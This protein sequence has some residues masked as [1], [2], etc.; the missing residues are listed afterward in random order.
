[1][2]CDQ[3]L[4]LKN[5][6]TGADVNDLKCVREIIGHEFTQR[7]RESAVTRLVPR[8]GHIRTREIASSPTCLNAV[9]PDRDF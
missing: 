4:R 6:L 9:D 5:R 7:H 8:L 2:D 1:M 3:I